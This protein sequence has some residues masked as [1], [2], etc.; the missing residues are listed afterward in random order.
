MEG[1]KNDEKDN[2]NCGSF[3]IHTFLGKISLAPTLQ[4]SWSLSLLSSYHDDVG[5]VCLLASAFILQS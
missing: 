1:L 4:Q 3:N 2:G 5:N